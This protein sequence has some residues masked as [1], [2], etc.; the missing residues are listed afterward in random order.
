MAR[1]RWGS[2]TI[3]LFAAIGS[4]VGLGNVWRFP[5]L[6]HKFGGGAFLIPYLIALFVMGIPLLILEFALGQKIQKGAIGSLKAVHSRLGGIGLL[7]V[8]TAFLIVCYYAVVMAWSLIYLFASFGVRWAGDSKTYFFSN[9]LN[10]SDSVGDVGGIKWTIFF[11]L[12]AVWVMIYFCIWKGPKS[13]GKVIWLTVPLPVILLAILFVR[14]VTL[15]GFLTGWAAYLRPDWSALL[16]SDVWIA[17]AGQIFFTL[18]VA[19]GIMIAYASYKNKNED[20]AKDGYITAITNCS[21]SLFAGFVVF[22]VLGYM[23]TQAGTSVTEAVASG[24]GLAFVVFPQ[25]LSLMPWA[26][27]FSVVFFLTLLS[28]G[29]DS[30][31]SIVEGVNV[32]ISD[33]KEKWKKQKIAF[34][35]CLLA[36]L[37]GILFTTRAGLYFLDIIDHFLMSYNLLIVG[38]LECLAVGWIYGADKMRRYINSVSD[39][40]VGRWWN[41]AIRYI[42]PLA[43]IILLVLN[44]WNEIHVPYEG[45]PGWALGIGWGVVIVPIVIML[46]MMIGGGKD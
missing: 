45:Y 22:G 15:P 14:A 16:Y 19:F 4:A 3:F 36:F 10:I 17:A 2:R 23:A 46:G 20:I 34:V 5:Y 9:V 41:A 35:V 31:F 13:V 40:K 29:I 25:A 7:G 38:I 26:A 32:V 33:A 12:L 30:A 44:F 6:A 27:F 11:A 8:L 43:L 18:S 21:I 28:L 39:W 24:P 1:D 42:I 37:I